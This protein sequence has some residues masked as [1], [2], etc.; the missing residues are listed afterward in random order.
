MPNTHINAFEVLLLTLKF[1][2]RGSE[3]V[4]GDPKK[5]EK[6]LKLETKMNFTDKL[7]SFDKIV[8]YN[9]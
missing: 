3:V 4:Q 1:S 7:L 8:Y 2:E 9:F 5:L 6:W